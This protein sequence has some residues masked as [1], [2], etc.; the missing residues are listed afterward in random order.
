MSNLRVF[1]Y[2]DPALIAQEKGESKASRSPAVWPSEASAI[3]LDKTIRGIVG[4]CHRAA[5]MRMT[6][7]PSTIEPKASTA[8][9]WILGREVEKNMTSQA[10]QSGIYA[11]SGIK[12]WIKELMISI[13]IDIVAIDPQD[14][15]GWLLECKSFSGYFAA[16]DIMVK[17][18]PKMENLIQICLYLNEVRNGARLKAM[19]RKSLLDRE[20]LDLKVREWAA[21]DVIFEH[22][23]R[24]EA[25]EVFETID[26]GPV[27]GKLV[28]LDRGDPKNRK[29]FTISIFT[30]S[31]GLTYPMVDGV[32]FKLFTLESVYDRFVTLQNYWFRARAE[33]YRRLRAR[34]VTAPS[35]LNLVTSRESITEYT[36]HVV[37][38][39]E[40]RQREDVYMAQLEEEV[41]RLPVEFLP[42]AEYCDTYTPE[43]VEHLFQNGAISKIKYNK[44][45]KGEVEKLG[46]WNCEF[47]SVRGHCLAAQSPQTYGYLA[48]DLR[49]MLQDDDTE[50]TFGK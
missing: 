37:L 11:A 47:C 17:N 2:L 10:Q 23:N 39:N 45:K 46:D 8:W 34:G 32:P 28:Y 33:A 24:T 29:E 6:G 4:K 1:D 40:E 36:G 20:A 3:L 9:S 13:E 42:P 16:Q 18:K 27:G 15:S 41:R 35:T 26:D 19:I 50:V 7:F 5:Y 31:D 12:H 43:Q 14:N 22:R 38:T 44:Y 25:W 30:D 48:E 21:Q 49:S